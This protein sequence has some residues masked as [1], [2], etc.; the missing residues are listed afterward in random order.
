[1]NEM[2]DDSRKQLLALKLVNSNAEPVQYGKD[3]EMDDLIVY[4][5]LFHE[6]KKEPPGELSANFSVNVLTRIRLKERKLRDSWFYLSLGGA[7][8]LSF[9]FGLIV[10][11]TIDADSVNAL[12]SSFNGAKLWL[13]FGIVCLLLIQVIDHGFIKLSSSARH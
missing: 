10:M 7:I 13:L 2:N 8:L 6:L 11:N 12:L 1:M 3:E 5:R 4:Q 9:C